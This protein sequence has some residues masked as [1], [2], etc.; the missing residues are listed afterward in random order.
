M[1]FLILP[2]ETIDFLIPAWLATRSLDLF[3]LYNSKKLSPVNFSSSFVL[4]KL[5]WSGELRGNC[6]GESYGE[7]DVKYYYEAYL[8]CENTLFWLANDLIERLPSFLRG[9][10]ALL[11]LKWFLGLTSLYVD[12]SSPSTMVT[13]SSKEVLLS[14]PAWMKSINYYPG[15]DYDYITLLSIEE[16]DGNCD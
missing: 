1:F 14:W 4:F 5:S 2:L 7:E 15:F 9:I 10:E 8:A 12:Y 13:I 11:A 16:C 3:L 6:E